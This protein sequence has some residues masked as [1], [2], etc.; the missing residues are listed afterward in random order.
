MA[1]IKEYKDYLSILQEKY[2]ELTDEILKDIAKYGFGKMF[3]IHGASGLFRLY[4]NNQI[5][6]F[7]ARYNV[8]KQKTAKMRAI[9]RFA[10]KPTDPVYY[11]IYTPR[12][13]IKIKA[14]LNNDTKQVFHLKNK[15]GYKFLEEA[16]YRAKPGDSI[17]S[18]PF[19]DVGNT[20]YFNTSIPKE[21]FKF[22]KQK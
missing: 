7:G 16:L 20:Y 6:S 10:K 8:I 1:S 12:E 15:C 18:I 22:I 19:I 13:C 21:Y 2:P 9:N 3:Y 17:Y 5:F 14:I 11:L 4:K